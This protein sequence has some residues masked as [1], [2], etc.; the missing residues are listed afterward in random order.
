MRL[1]LLSFLALRL[2]PSVFGDEAPPPAEPEQK[3]VLHGYLSQ[4]FAISNDHQ[5]L[6]ITSDG[7]SDYR[8]AALQLRVSVTPKDSL[9]VQ[10]AH[11]R[12]GASPTMKIRDDLALDWIFYEHTF[13]D[14][15]SARVGKVKIPFGIYNE[16][17]YVGP[18]L[19][20]FR[21]ADVFYGDGT[22]S[23]S[24]LNGAVL[25]SRIAPHSDVNLDLDVYAGEWSFV[26]SD[27]LTTAQA[28]KG[29]GL[30]AWIN[31][32]LHGARLGFALNHS[33]VSNLLYKTPEAKEGQL[34]WAVSGDGNFS[35]LHVNAELERTA[36]PNGAFRASY[37]LAS[38]R[39]AGK[40]SLTAQIAQSH[41]TV[42]APFPF[43]GEISRDA[44]LGAHYALRPYLT[45]KAETH[46]V[47]GLN[48]EDPGITQATPA[49]QARY[50]IA[51]I[52]AA[53]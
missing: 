1:L 38:W 41:L 4:A 37:L 5:V 35:R 49:L 43:D 18:L 26:Q 22:Y 27:G 7:T 48:F 13:G 20:F 40:L 14:G 17:R 11:E 45:L 39:V 9:V 30:Q 25:S 51:S 53:F 31:T 19:P 24:S 46:W 10:V 23:F 34:K 6:G 36:A 12:L 16:V 44:A 29:T 33:T 15:L 2:V 32:P 42:T 3:I 28:K 21:A 8:T 47:R 50:F 52:S